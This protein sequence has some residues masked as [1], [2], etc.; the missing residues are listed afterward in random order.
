MIIR[1]NMDYKVMFKYGF[2]SCTR[3]SSNLTRHLMNADWRFWVKSRNLFPLIINAACRFGRFYFPLIKR[4]PQMFSAWIKEWIKRSNSINYTHA[5]FFNAFMDF[6]RLQSYE[7]V[8]SFFYVDFEV[9][10]CLSHDLLPTTQ[11]YRCTDNDIHSKLLILVRETT[12]EYNKA[13]SELNIKQQKKKVLQ[14]NR[15]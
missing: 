10:Q 4:R 11:I 3:Y 2:L 13:K 7:T 6:D 12:E 14:E 1:E 15:T 9:T 5:F 8:F